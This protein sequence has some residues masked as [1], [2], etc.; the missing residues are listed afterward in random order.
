MRHP[1]G[2]GLDRGEDGAALY[3]REQIIPATL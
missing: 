2:H 3:H 1:Q